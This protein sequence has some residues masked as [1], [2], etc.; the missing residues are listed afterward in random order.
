VDILRV[1]GYHKF[2]NKIFDATKVALSKLKE[3]FT[4]ESTSKVIDIS[5]YIIQLS[6][7]LL[8]TSANRRGES[9]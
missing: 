9:R 6:L 5:S 8:L 4:P 3:G 2:C 1:Q 7:T